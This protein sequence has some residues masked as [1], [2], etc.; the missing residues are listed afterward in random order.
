MKKAFLMLLLLLTLG[1]GAA[2]AQQGNTT[3]IR[4]PG[5]ATGACA[6]LTFGINSATGDLYDCVG[7]SYVKVGS[8][9]SGGGA[10]ASPSGS[11]QY[12]NAGA[13]GAIGQWA[14]GN[15]NC[16]GF[17]D[18]CDV[19]VTSG[20]TLTY[21]LAG[22][23]TS[24]P[25]GNYFGCYQFTD[26][27]VYC[28]ASDGTGNG[29]LFYAPSDGNVGMSL[30]DGSKVSGFNI[31]GTDRVVSIGRLSFNSSYTSSP[32]AMAYALGAGWG[33]T[34]SVTAE[35]G[36]DN[37]FLFTIT[38]GGTGIAANPTVT[39]TYADGDFS[40]AS[41]STPIFVCIQTGGNDIY[42]DVPPTTPGRTTVVM[43]WLGTPT[44]GKTYTIS[45]HDFQRS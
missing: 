1:A 41:A 3:T 15:A 43:T 16:D 39:Y 27:G 42:A 17:M 30:F 8:G 40:T 24:A 14:N 32:T 7:G 45:C 21:F 5:A 31:S 25:M 19:L 33:S 11:I 20:A 36:S 2:V 4:F 12:N 22:T 38:T 35:G 44:N 10:P 18:P 28:N 6:P 37:A 13:F 34:A 26:A 9:G 29:S 23:N